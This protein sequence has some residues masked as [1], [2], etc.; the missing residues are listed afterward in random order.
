MGLDLSKNNLSE[1]AEV[2]YEFEL[3]MPGTNEGTG[4]FITV[5]GAQSPK[6]KNFAKKKF[7][8]MQLKETQAK[9]KGRDTDPMT[10]DEAEEMAIESAAIRVISWKGIE[11][12]EKAIPCTEEN[13]K[14]VLKDHAW[15]REQ[16]LEESDQIV[17]F[18]KS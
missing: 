5:R 18:I 4:A 6:V 9:R 14:R 16:V 13:V 10:L 2:G 8:E 1:L 11:E 15:I 3:K 17:N 7:N 12:G